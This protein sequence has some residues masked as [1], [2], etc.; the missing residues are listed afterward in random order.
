MAVDF[1]IYYKKNQT[2]P[3]KQNTMEG[4]SHSTTAQAPTEPKP[5]HMRPI[6]SNKKQTTSNKRAKS[7]AIHAP[8]QPIEYELIGMLASHERYPEDLK[9]VKVTLSIPTPDDECPIALEP[10]TTAHL[11]FLPDCSFIKDTPQYSKMTL[12]CGHSFSAMVVI[13]NFCKNGMI[14]PCCRQGPQR[15]ANVNYLPVHFKDQLKAHVTSSL[16]AE[17]VEDERDTIHTLLNMTPMTMSFESLA[18][19][20]CLEMIINFYFQPN[21]EPN[22]LLSPSSHRTTASRGHF[23]MMVRLSPVHMVR[24]ERVVAVFRPYASHMD[25][26]RQSPGEAMSINIT[27]QMRIL[28]AGII[29]IDSSGE[30]NFPNFNSSTVSTE[31]GDSQI[32]YICR[33]VV[34]NSTPVNGRPSPTVP[35]I[36]ISTFELIFRKQ[37]DRVFLHGVTWVPDSSHVHVSLNRAT[38]VPQ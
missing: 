5:T 1:T 32:P 27:T 6:P 15:R 30:I 28:N 11:E 26:I 16:S 38:G 35:N 25:V 8:N 33:R 10:I 37:D 2:D 7:A 18:N 12:P 22:G 14:C 21:I 34:G 20:G 36:P 19:D 3:N 4:S 29:D 9:K 31:H 23:S 24:R 17:Q 13:Y